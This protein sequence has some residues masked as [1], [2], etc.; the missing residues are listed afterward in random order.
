LQPLLN[1]ESIIEYT[2]GSYSGY[3]AL[4]RN[5]IGKGAAYHLGWYPSTAQLEGIIKM[6]SE[7][8][9]LPSPESPPPGTS[10][11]LR[12]NNHIY[13][14]FTNQSIEISKEDSNFTIAP[15]D[16]LVK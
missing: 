10:L 6:I 2:S 15:R 14:N 4:A 16:V 12:G 13:L 5:K 8:S 9:L 1:G 11:F 3:S 7:D